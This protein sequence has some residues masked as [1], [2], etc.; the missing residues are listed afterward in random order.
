MTA[1]MPEI[2]KDV[3]ARRRDR[4]NFALLH[5]R[6]PLRRGG[7]GRGGSQVTQNE[8]GSGRRTGWRIPAGWPPIEDNRAGFRGKLDVERRAHPAPVRRFGTEDHPDARKW[9]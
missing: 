3:K 8:K 9:G 4:R 5:D 6:T 2:E 1:A 7:K